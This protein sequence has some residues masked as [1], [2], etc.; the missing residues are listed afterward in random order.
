MLPTH[1]RWSS[2]TVDHYKYNL[3]FSSDYIF[4]LSY[5]R[6]ITEKSLEMFLV[7]TRS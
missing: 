7:P 5:V 3:T 2:L 1:V 6:I 4:I